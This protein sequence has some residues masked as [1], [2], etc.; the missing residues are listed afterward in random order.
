MKTS[1]TRPAMRCKRLPPPRLKGPVE[2][3]SAAALAD[4]T[5]AYGH[6]TESRSVQYRGLSSL[7]TRACA[8]RCRALPDTSAA[9]RTLMLLMGP[10]WHRTVSAASSGRI[11]SVLSESPCRSRLVRSW[12]SAWDARAPRGG[13]WSASTRSSRLHPVPV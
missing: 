13:P 8:A 4:R 1:Q 2:G 12:H 5:I 7:P 6:R 3:A 9:P 10:V 11:H